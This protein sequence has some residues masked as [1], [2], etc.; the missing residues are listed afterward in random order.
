MSAVL[1][2]ERTRRKLAL[3]K[4][5]TSDLRLTDQDFRVLWYIADAIDGETGL[6][7]RKQ[8]TIASEL[9]KKGVRGV[10]L[11]LGRLAEFG[12][13]KFEIKEGGKYVNAYRLIVENANEGSPSLDKNAN[14]DAPLENQKTNGGSPL[15]PDLSEK[16]NESDEKG[17]PPFVHD[18]PLSIPK[19]AAAA[20]DD[21]SK[22]E[23]ELTAKFRDI[24]AGEYRKPPDMGPVRAWLT[25]GIAASTIEAVVIPK[26]RRKADMR[27]LAYCDRAVR[28]AHAASSSAAPAP[29]DIDPDKVWRD[30]LRRF[31]Q[32]GCWTMYTNE[33]GPDPTSP[34]CKAP[35]HLLEE[36]GLARPAA[37]AAALPPPPHSQPLEALLLGPV[38]QAF[39]YAGKTEEESRTTP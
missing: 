32:T 11:S 39:F 21:V 29:A 3:M 37:S 15:G 20:R 16:A 30:H 26:I 24:S 19:E 25:D 4:R 31:K 23:A 22:I 8:A 33:Y 35:A 36:F 17:E 28:E 10:Q 9:G 13:L 1:D 38:V 2:K 5:A 34:G 27:S 12:Y 6:A 7:R 18:L 14:S